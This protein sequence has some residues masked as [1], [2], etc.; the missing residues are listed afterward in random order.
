MEI[1]FLR[2][3]IIMGKNGQELDMILMVMLLIILNVEK[4]S[5]KNFLMMEY[6]NLKENMIMEKEMEKEKDMIMKIKKFYSKE[7][8]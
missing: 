6:L 1:A 5:L 8:I 2:G 7:N 3:V 4:D